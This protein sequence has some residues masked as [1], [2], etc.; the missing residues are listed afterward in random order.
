MIPVGA[1]LAAAVVVAE[2]A[3]GG[4]GRAGAVVTEAAAAE[5]RLPVAPAAA[6]VVAA[7]AEAEVDAAALLEMH[8]VMTG[9]GKFLTRF[10]IRTACLPVGIA[11][12]IAVWSLPAQPGPFFLN[13]IRSFISLVVGLP[14]DSNL[15]LPKLTLLLILLFIGLLSIGR[16][17]CLDYS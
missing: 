7:E 9:S 16:M 17:L 15:Q 14:I 13:L 4:G 5:A 2:A 11:F 8:V 12:G 6:T 10:Q 1:G 3:V